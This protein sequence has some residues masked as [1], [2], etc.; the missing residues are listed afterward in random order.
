M[1]ELIAKYN[2]KAIERELRIK[3]LEQINAALRKQID[4]EQIESMSTITTLLATIKEL[5]NK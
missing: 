1:E 3:E 2:R 4:R 5:R